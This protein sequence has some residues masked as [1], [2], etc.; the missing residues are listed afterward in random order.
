MENLQSYRSAVSFLTQ[1]STVWLAYEL[2][3]IE[4]MR[5]KIKWN[6]MQHII[7]IDTLIVVKSIKMNGKNVF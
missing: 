1:K 5:D 6:I 4:L 3:W 2:K 7:F